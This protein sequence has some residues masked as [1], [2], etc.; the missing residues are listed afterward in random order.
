MINEWRKLTFSDDELA[1]A[2]T[3]Y[4]QAARGMAKDHRLGDITISD[5]Q[6]GALSVVV[7]SPCGSQRSTIELKPEAVAALLVAHCMRTKT[8]LPRRANKSIAVE[9]DRLSL[10]LAL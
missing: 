9:G 5:P 7:Y 4:L 1:A 3:S 8:P 6:S 2:V 10:V